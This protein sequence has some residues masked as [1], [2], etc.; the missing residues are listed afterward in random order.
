MNE[1]HTPRNPL[2]QPRLLLFLMLAVSSALSVVLSVLRIWYSETRHFVF[3]NWNLVL[4]WVPLGLALLLWRLDRQRSPRPRLLMLI[5]FGCWLLF[6]PNSPYILSDL[7][8]I[9][10]RDNVPLWYDA[11][12]IF[13]FA[14]NGLMLGFVSLW[15]VQQLTARW[16][17]WLVSWLFVATTLAAT[18][19]GIYLG[20]F[21]RWNSWD[22]LVD[23]LGMARQVLVYALNPL[24]YPRTVGVTLLFGAFLTVAYLTLTLLPAAL[25]KSLAEGE[26][27]RAD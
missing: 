2:L 12:M 20:R 15:I 21:Q 13:S 9:G 19:F 27:V 7:M 25:G 17:G 14:W 11:M 3:L 24:D 5:I 16:F 22:V 18:G 6:F 8:H 26:R 4:A 1:P 10:P 23:P